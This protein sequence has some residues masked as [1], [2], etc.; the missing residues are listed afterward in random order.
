MIP[1]I[2]SVVG[3]YLIG[4]SMKKEKVSSEDT[5]AEDAKA[6]TREI[7]AVPKFYKSYSDGGEVEKIKIKDI[8]NLDI[9]ESD[10]TPLNLT[11]P[12]PMQ[13]NISRFIGDVIE[14]FD[15]VKKKF[16]KN[17]YVVRKLISKT[18]KNDFSHIEI[19]GTYK[20]K[21]QAKEALL[22]SYIDK[23]LIPKADEMP[24]D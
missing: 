19:I 24:A 23:D 22:N 5:I 3:G 2:L 17:S 6:R 7:L 18:P 14:D 1:F 11:V 15:E 21:E 12:Y 13:S 10:F 4:E 16:K 20:T 8:P 9:Y